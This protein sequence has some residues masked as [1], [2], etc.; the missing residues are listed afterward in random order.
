[1]AGE[2]LKLDVSDFVPMSEIRDNDRF[3]M[4]QAANAHFAASMTFG[5]FREK[6]LTPIIESSK[7]NGMGCEIFGSI[8]EY[9]ALSELDPKTMYVIIESGQITQAFL[10]EYPF[11]VGG[12]GGGEAG[13]IPIEQVFV[14]LEAL[15]LELGETKK[16]TATYEPADATNTTLSWTTSNRLVATVSNGLVTSVGKGECLIRVKARSGVFSECVITIE[17][18]LIGLSFS[19]VNNKLVSGHTTQLEPIATPENATLDLIYTCSDT[20]KAMVDSKTGVVTPIMDSGNVTINAVNKNGVRASIAMKIVPF[21]VS[22]VCQGI[23]HTDNSVSNIFS[24]WQ[25]T[26]K[27]NA[28]CYKYSETIKE[29]GAKSTLQSVDWTPMP[30]DGIVDIELYAEFGYKYINW[31]FKNTDGTFEDVVIAPVLYKE[32]ELITY[33]FDIDVQCTQEEAQTMTMEVPYYK[34]DK[35][36]VYNLRNDDNLTSLWRMAFR[37]CNREILPKQIKRYERPDN[38]MDALLPAERRRSPRRLGYTNGCGVVIPFVFDVAGTVQEGSGLTFDNGVNTL[39]QRSDILKAKDYGGHFLLHN[40]VFLDSDPIKPKYENDYSYPLQRDRET[41]LQNF[42]YTSV[43]FANPDGDPYYTQPCIKDPKTLLMS[44]GGYAFRRPSEL[45]QGV[46]GSTYGERFPDAVKYYGL[47]VHRTVF[48]W[49]S[50]LSNVPLS[51]IRNTLH[52]GYVFANN[53]PYISNLWKEQY[54]MAL[55]GKPSLATELTHGLGYDLESNGWVNSESS[56][57][58]KLDLD[59]FEEVFD[60]VGANGSDAIWF[61]P[62]DESIEYMYYQRVA[63][64]TKKLT[65]TGCRFTIGV[66]IPDYLSYKTYS[67]VIKNLPENAIVTRGQG[68]TMF[69]K[70][71][72][73]GL[74][75][76]GY[77]ADIPERASRYVQQYLSN[78]TNE[79][80]DKA[81]YFVKQLG[82]LQSPYVAVLPAFS[83]KPILASVSCPASVATASVVATTVNSNKEF[84]EAEFLDVSSSSDFSNMQ[85]YAIAT[86]EHKWY[87]ALDDECLK[88]RFE[89]DIDP[90]FNVQQDKYVRLRNVYG[91]SDVKTLAVTLNRIHGINDPKLVVDANLIYFTKEITLSI[92]Y[93][94]V[95]ELRYKHN[96]GSYSSWIAIANK[97]PVTLV[98]GS[99]TI[100]VEARNNLNETVSQEIEASFVTAEW[101]VKATVAFLDSFTR[102]EPWA[103]P[104]N[105]PALFPYI[106]ASGFTKLPRGEQKNYNNTPLYDLNMINRGVVTNINSFVDNTYGFL[107]WRGL[108]NENHY[109][110]SPM[111]GN[112]SA[113]HPDNMIAKIT[114]AGNVQS[115]WKVKDGFSG[116]SAFMFRNLSPGKYIVNLFGRHLVKEQ[117]G[118]GIAF[119]RDNKD[120]VLTNYLVSKEFNGQ[121]LYDNK[122]NVIS[123][124]FEVIAA[125]QE[126]QIGM[127]A[128]FDLFGNDATDRQYGF[129]AIHLIKILE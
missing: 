115:G 123:L 1:M 29:N 113:T 33:N 57:I 2:E 102:G 22:V 4:T 76:F 85:S 3:M 53:H 116:R 129:N 21:A 100:V 16:L 59:F 19:S 23:E 49:F 18:T 9:N 122:E 95:S 65:Q 58:L 63:K 103:S 43:T 99:N 125:T 104:T 80:L 79:N 51:E 93:T 105:N 39:V 112:D 7:P 34:Y 8:D 61:C 24:K 75:N 87:D 114:T 32:P 82:E 97:L 62:S 54:Q 12:N 88:N 36:F 11:N 72:K 78:P 64:I 6:I 111:T 31:T 108:G 74:I 117:T 40:M 66:Q 28:T 77:S 35:K 52:T 120:D 121:M 47:P 55:I 50:D 118:T 10:G 109:A 83:E 41:L 26:N 45:A 84:G 56:A 14:D 91:E 119:V 67:V 13:S 96:G 73:T 15:V 20:S 110:V 5:T 107:I 70:N 81:W 44:G 124:E 42:G 89:I 27:G 126:F 48:S 101:E 30:A 86:G 106:P 90:L 46:N 127:D 68:V 38:E 17:V 98:L 60:T 92:R 69:H 25:L 128:R 94:N 71:M 37:F